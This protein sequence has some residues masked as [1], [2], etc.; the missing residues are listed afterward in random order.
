[1]R[2]FSG[3]LRVGSRDGVVPD[4][5]GGRRGRP[6]AVD[7]GHLQRT[8][9]GGWP[10]GETGD[11]AVRPLPPLRRG[12]GS[13]GRGWAR[14]PTG[15][16]W[17]GRGSSRPGPGRSNQPGLDFYRRLVGR[18]ARAGHHP[19]RH[20]V[21]LG[22]AAGAGGRAAAGGPATPRPGSPTTP[23]S[24]PT[25]WP[26]STPYWITLNE[27]YCSAIIGYA[28]GRHAPGAREGHGALAAAH[29]LLLGHGLAVPA[30]RAAGGRR[31]GL[32]AQHV[33]RGAG[34]RRRGRPGRGRSAGPAGNR[35]FTDPVL[36]GRLPGDGAEELWGR[37]PT[38]PSATTA[39][40]PSSAPRWTSSASTT[41][42]ACTCG[43][44]DARA[45]RALGHTRSAS[46]ARIRPMWTDHRARL[47]DRA[48][49]AV[50]R[51]W[52]ACGSR[53]PDLPPIYITE[54]G[55]A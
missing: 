31:V 21:P 13:G 9:P 24:W 49:R 6:R 4:R 37:T 25:R 41:T 29:H 54:N 5:G 51:R 32:D 36:G 17:P 39:I 26:S 33:A 15:S 12:P 44:A 45:R 11:V 22:P 23:R 42:T 10:G 35:L 14:A 40:W 30:L 47:A 18:A 27:P 3:R 20:A 55:C 53:Y 48:G 38:S 43:R 1:M 52:P 16:R 7:L 34:Q 46:P 28:E 19:V 8:P 2:R 50:R